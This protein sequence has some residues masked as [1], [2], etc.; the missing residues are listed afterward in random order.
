M[1]VVEIKSKGHNKQ[2]KCLSF[3]CVLCF[4]ISYTQNDETS[5]NIPY[6]K[7]NKFNYFL[8]FFLCEMYEQFV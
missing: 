3:P 8:S 7:T 6:K 4:E 1:D 2:H 5:K